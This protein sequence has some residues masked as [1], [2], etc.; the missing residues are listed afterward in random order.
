MSWAYDTPVHAGLQCY[1]SK[2]IYCKAKMAL[3]ID[4]EESVDDLSKDSNAVGRTFLG[5]RRMISRCCFCGWW[6]VEK[7][8][9]K[10]N[11][12]V[13]FYSAYGQ[14]KALDIKDISTPLNEVRSYLA[15]KYS[16]RFHVDPFLYEQTVGSVFRDIGYQ[17]L[18]TAPS[19][20]WGIDVYLEDIDGSLIGV[21][22][23]R[24]KGAIN[25]EQITALT[26]ALVIN[27]CTRGVFVTTSRFRPGAVVAAA[28][29]SSCGFPA[30]LINGKK[31]YEL[32]RIAQAKLNVPP[33]DPEMPWN[34]ITPGHFMGTQ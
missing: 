30:E 34:K 18:V 10:R 26:G 12:H 5:A 33:Y 15:A 2:C 25:V 16:A 20:D 4:R 8:Y 27:N 19:G 28:R 24:W 9:D 1:R 11:G 6:R 21:Q 22:V 3:I 17:A 7:W 13:D 32:L 31:F 29:S 23:K 14:L